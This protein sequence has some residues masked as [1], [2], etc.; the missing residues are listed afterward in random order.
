[1]IDLDPSQYYEALDFAAKAHKGQVRKKSGDPYIMHPMR[2]AQL[3]CLGDQAEEITHPA[4]V[5]AALLH[6]VVEDTAV[7]QEQIDERFDPAAADLVETM[8]RVA[9]ENKQE[10]VKRVVHHSREAAVLKMADRLDNL[11]E[12]IGSYSPSKLR[13]Y[14]DGTKY[15]FSE[16]EWKWGTELSALDLGIALDDEICRAEALLAP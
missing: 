10:Y 4:M 14:L 13:A 2:V 5:V 15:L 9:S 6:D 1:M 7:T 16:V 8:T 12:A 3:L 11:R